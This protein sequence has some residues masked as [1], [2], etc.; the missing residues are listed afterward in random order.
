MDPD[1]PL[2]L[3]NSGVGASGIGFPL[4]DANF[5]NKS[6]LCDLIVATKLYNYECKMSH[7]VD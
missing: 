1:A 4:K 5:S 2:P 7:D 3:K 6:G